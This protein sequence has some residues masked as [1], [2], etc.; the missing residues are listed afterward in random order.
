VR[1]RDQADPDFFTARLNISSFVTGGLTH[2]YSTFENVQVFAG[3]GGSDIT[4][5]AVPFLAL[6]AASTTTVFGGG[7]DD[8]ITIGTGNVGL[9]GNIFID[10]TFHQNDDD[11]LV[12]NDSTVGGDSA[13]T[14]DQGNRFYKGN[15]TYSVSPSDV[16][17]T[18]LEANAGDNTIT[19]ES[20]AYPLT[21]QSNAGNDRVIV[22]DTGPAVTV[23]TGSENV[24]TTAPFGDSIEINTD[25]AVPGDVRATVLIDQDDTVLGLT[26]A[27]SGTLRIAG[28]AVLEKAAGTGN[29]FT[30]NGTI[31]MAGGALLSR[32]GAAAPNFRTLLTRGFAS[33]VWNGTSTSGA[34][35]SS[36]AANS[37]VSDGV[38]H[39]LARRSLRAASAH[40]GSPRATSCSATRSTATQIWTS[41]STSPTS[42]VWPQLRTHRQSL[43]QRRLQLRR[44]CEPERFQPARR[45]L[46]RDG[47]RRGCINASRIER[48]VGL[49]RSSEQR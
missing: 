43:G 22:L 48:H 2:S 3:D 32:A 30:V 29:S 14:F 4:V 45:Q 36:F 37:I 38:G 9:R 20:F 18:V 21:I 17:R 27:Q 5:A 28:D 44:L 42:T 7:E 10:G 49:V 31:D 13:Y 40:S 24:S 23:N 19:V 46:W 26:V 39:G 15:P 34:I 11:T 1:F 35:N 16:E 47:G 41:T 33:G 6:P 25:F 8:L 12:L